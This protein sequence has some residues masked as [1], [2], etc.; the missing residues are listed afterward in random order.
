MDEYSYDKR[1]EN[2]YFK[3]PISREFEQCHFKA[4]DFTEVELHQVKFLACT[5]ETCN[6]SNVKLE[7]SSFQDCTFA[8][9]KMLGLAFDNC[10]PFNLSMQ[11]KECILSHASFSGLNLTQCGF[12]Q[13]DLTGVDFGYCDLTQA[14]LTNCKMTDTLFEQTILQKADMRD[15]INYQIDPDNNTIKG[16]RFSKEEIIGLLA[17][18]QI[19]IE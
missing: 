17:K 1:F 10:N 14:K 4:C 12:D 8:Q 2:E 11:F 7:K 5:F 3:N 9:C 18:Y 19:I 16:A 13:C 6:L 15:S